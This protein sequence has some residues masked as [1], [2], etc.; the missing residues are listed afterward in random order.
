MADYRMDP[1][2]TLPGTGINATPETDPEHLLPEHTH[3][4]IPGTIAAAASDPDAVRGEIERTRQRMSHTIDQLESVLQRKKGEI[5][6][7]LDFVA[8][9]REKPWM[10]AAGVF[11][12]GIALGLLTGGRNGED[13]DHVKVPRALLAGMDMQEDGT[14]SNGADE[15]RARSRE[16]LGVIAQQ[17]EEIRDLRAALYGEDEELEAYAAMAEDDLGTEMDALADVDVEDEW[18]ADWNFDDQDDALNDFGAFGAEGERRGFLGKAVAG[19]VAAGL[20][21]A[22]SGL[23]KKLVGRHRGGDEPD[24]EVELEP[25]RGAATDVRQ[26][27]AYLAARRARGGDAGYRGEMDVEVELEPRRTTGWGGGMDVEVELEPPYATRGRSRAVSPL[28]GAV[29]AG[30][31]ALV[32][33]LATRLVRGRRER[34]MDAEVELEEIP[35]APR[36]ARGGLDVEVEMEGRGH[37]SSPQPLTAER[38]YE[39]ELERPAGDPRGGTGDVPLM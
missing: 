34:E 28:A 16:L 5:Q 30:A 20:A 25:R 7:R 3:A 31:A 12:T 15:Y 36:A 9:V 1:D 10:F 17:E 32:G 18:D 11:G 13:R 39:V 22:I 38:Q 8:P 2:R 37:T 14:L 35:P 29:A 26:E 19:A 21:G 4:A 23:G 27:P 24:V 6:D 33:G